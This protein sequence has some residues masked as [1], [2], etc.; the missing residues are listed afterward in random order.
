MPSTGLSNLISLSDS[1]RLRQSTELYRAT[2][3]KKP[4]PRLDH[5]VV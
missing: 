1:D 5:E 4:M 3:A 2:I